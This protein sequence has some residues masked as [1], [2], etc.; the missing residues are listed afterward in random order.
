MI[1]RIMFFGILASFI[2]LVFYSVTTLSLWYSIDLLHNFRGDWKNFIFFSI[3]LYG[4]L[5]FFQN[6][7]IE[8]INKKWNVILLFTLILIIYFIGWGEDFTSWPIKTSLILITG[9]ITL[10]IKFLFDLN[11]KNFKSSKIQQFKTNNN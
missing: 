5:I 2:Q 4:I 11:F 6:I 3:P 1:K 9:T 8:I 7:I 10:M